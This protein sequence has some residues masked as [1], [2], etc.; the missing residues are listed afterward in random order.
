MV[1]EFGGRLLSKAA[2]WEGLLSPQVQASSRTLLAEL[3]R[4]PA[5]AEEQLPDIHVLQAE[6]ANCD[7]QRG[8]ALLSSSAGKISNARL[9]SNAPMPLQQQANIRHAFASTEGPRAASRIT[10]SGANKLLLPGSP[11]WFEQL[12]SDVLSHD[13]QFTHAFVFRF[14]LTRICR[15]Q[16]MLWGFTGIPAD[17]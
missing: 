4:Q 17:Q 9:P 3:A 2:S 10:P 16:G 7:L 6:L 14:L 1:V 8:H 12:G 15:V 5:W 13:L 11:L